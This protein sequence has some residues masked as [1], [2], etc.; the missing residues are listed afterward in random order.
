MTAYVL[1]F[2]QNLRLKLSQETNAKEK[3]FGPLSAEEIQDAEEHWTKQA[4]SSLFERMQK[5]DFKTLTGP[6]EEGGGGW[7]RSNEPPLRP[8][9]FIFILAVADLTEHRPLDCQ[10]CQ[11]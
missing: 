1:R 9:I 2:C 10:D 7:T 8:K 6:Q 3:Q 11:D 4:Q 5:G